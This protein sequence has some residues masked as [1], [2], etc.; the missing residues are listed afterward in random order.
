[1]TGFVTIGQRN[2]APS[3]RH[4]GHD[5]YGVDVAADDA[6][7]PLRLWQSIGGGHA[8]CGGSVTL[9]IDA[10]EQWSGDWR[11]HLQRAGCDWAIAPLQAALAGAPQA[12]A[13]ARL[14]AGSAAD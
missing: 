7:A 5:V 8:E 13:L 3:T 10:L 4:P 14:R 12:E 9:A 2:H 1:M 11:Q 6:A